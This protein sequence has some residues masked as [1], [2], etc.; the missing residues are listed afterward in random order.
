MSTNQNHLDPLS[1]LSF[2]LDGLQGP[3]TPLSDPAST[4]VP[5]YSA[6][7]ARATLAGD[8]SL[9]PSQH[10]F[11]TLLSIFMDQYHVILPCL[12]QNRLHTRMASEY[13]AFESSPQ[14]WVIAGC[15]TWYQ[16]EGHSLQLSE[17]FLH[18]ASVLIDENIKTVKEPLITLQSLVYVIYQAYLSASMAEMWIYLGK[19]CRLVSMLSWNRI[20]G[21]AAL[22]PYAP[23]ASSEEEK[24]ERRRVV[25]AL[26]LLDR[27]MSCLTGWSLALDDRQFMVNYPMPEARFQQGD[28]S[29]V[30]PEP[31]S[32]NLAKLVR[33]ELARTELKNDPMGLIFHGY[34][35]LGRILNCHNFLHEESYPNFITSEFFELEDTLTKFHL[36]ADGATLEPL[37]QPLQNRCKSAWLSILIMTCTILL[38]HPTVDDASTDKARSDLGTASSF[39]Y[40]V[41]A[42]RKIMERIREEAIY[43]METLI[44]PLLL[45]SYFLVCR[46]LTI[47]W[48]ESKNMQ[49]RNSIDTI[50][51]LI[52]RIGN[53]YGP[54]A[55]KY[56][57][58]IMA[59]VERDPDT[60]RRLRRGTGSYLGEE[61]RS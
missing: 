57:K 29:S 22:S 1:G 32:M 54:L 47:T 49:D 27:A 58:S 25:W 7:D 51:M 33:P 45:P 4:S 13:E 61:C 24:E 53:R 11:A 37:E 19:A 39:R 59:D 8:K 2:S 14:F 41:S 36:I 34:T 42:T 18:R 23:K 55:L 28:F 38:Y 10:E 6:P 9:A 21:R 52:D 30:T 43:S 20:D 48:H 3:L 5:S 31:F 46:F 16:R 50:L 12:H 60:M 56:R 15:A 17:T 44:N 26:F 40:C 35:L